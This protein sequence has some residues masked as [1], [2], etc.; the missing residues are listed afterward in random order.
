MSE[1]IDNRRHRLV[2]LKQLI[3]E[4]HDGAPPEALKG[5]FRAVLDHVGASEISALES[6]LMAEGMPQDEIKRMCDLHVAVFRDT[7]E[8]R[9]PAEAQPGHPVHTFRAENAEILRLVEA[10]Q[11]LVNELP[12]VG[13]ES[14]TPEQVRRWR[15]LQ[16]RLE[17]LD[18]HYKRKEFLLFPFLEK[19]GITAP[20]KVMWGV[21]DDVREK[22]AAAREAAAAAAGARGEDLRLIRQV[23]LEP[24]LTAVAA[25]VEKE[26][27]VLFPMALEHL[28]D[29][30]WGEVQ[31]QWSDFGP[32]L[33]TPGEGWTPAIPAT[34]AHVAE[35]S[36]ADTVRLPSGHFTLS[37]LAA[38]LNTLPLD[39][40]FVD[41]EDRVTFFT[42]GSDRIFARNRAIIG[43]RVQ[44][45][46]PPSSMHIVQRIL[47]EMRTGRREV[48][49][50][51]LEMGPRFV[52]IRYFAVRDADKAYLGCLE[53]TQ[54]VAGIRRLEGQRRL[55]A[56]V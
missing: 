12:V 1:L 51:W 43:R 27:R 5:R 23:V 55:L 47:D 14:P 17:L 52:H 25:M 38:V 48:A 42:E 30:E 9:P 8:Q 41:A 20:P 4:L 28:A 13:D 34:P 45:C 53:V 39:A 6:E 15:E 33:A 36:A 26:E 40:T 2:A 56:E 24:M 21:D 54:D 10:Y 44:D 31:Q 22:L 29:T 7:L 50:F 37:Q 19:A 3:R 18:G 11:A 35:L 16:A 49:E 32:G 46:H